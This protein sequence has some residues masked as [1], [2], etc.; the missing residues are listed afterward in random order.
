MSDA[1]TPGSG[2]AGWQQ[3]P[4]GRHEYRYWDGSAWTDNVSD[5]G[6]TSVDPLAPAGAPDA[7][8]A[9]QSMPTSPPTAPISM[10]EPVA[11]PGPAGP[12]F[13]PPSGPPP[14]SAS[15]GGGGGSKTP[16]IIGAVVVVALAIAGFLVFAGGSDASNGAGTFTVDVPK[17]GNIAHKVSLKDNEFLLVTATPQDKKMDVVL[18]LALDVKSAGAKAIGD[19][20][21][22][23]LSEDSS[24]L[25]DNGTLPATVV[26][27]VN[28]A[29]AGKKETDAA[30][31]PKGYDATIV[32]GG[33]GGTAGKVELKLEVV[34]V[35]ANTDRVAYLLE[36][37]SNP[38]VKSF[39]SSGCN[40]VLSDSSSSSRSSSRSSSTS[41]SD[42][43]NSFSDF[44]NLSDFS[45]LFSDFSN[46]TD[47]FSS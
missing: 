16:L 27:T 26:S 5:S 10:P 33:A 6:A 13:T 11:T 31:A 12:T 24:D 47:F 4:S 7:V 37:C 14:A 38:A 42:F 20:F 19:F 23:T 15:S 3:D 25:S 45:S 17:N 44:S 29:G 2:P 28:K 36:A 18:G 39:D 21:S 35:K 41:F 32:V 43:S 34:K 40:A 22:Q 9:T 46:F 30:P 1:S 8:P